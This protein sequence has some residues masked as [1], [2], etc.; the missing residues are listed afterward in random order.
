MKARDKDVDKHI[1]F[2]ETKDQLKACQ[3]FI[4][5]LRDI[6]LV[7]RGAEIVHYIKTHDLEKPPCAQTVLEMLKKYKIDPRPEFDEN[8]VLNLD[9][10]LNE[11]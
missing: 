9:F 4:V 3:D 6:P 5:S 7:D 10:K 11:D 1:S 8:Y 2:E